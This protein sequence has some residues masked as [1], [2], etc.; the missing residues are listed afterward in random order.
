MEMEDRLALR[1]AY[2][3]SLPT[4]LTA[5]GL[6]ICRWSKRLLRVCARYLEV[7]GYAQQQEAQHAL[8]VRQIVLMKDSAVHVYACVFYVF[9]TCGLHIL[10]PFNF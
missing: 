5:A 9:L 3:A 10:S 1:L 4:L 2:I 8:L 6:R 7:A